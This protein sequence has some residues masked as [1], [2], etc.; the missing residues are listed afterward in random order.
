[1]KVET[2][3]YYCSKIFYMK[4][5]LVKI[6]T[7]HGR[8]CSA[9]CRSKFAAQIANKD[10]I[11]KVIKNC[12]FCG[13]E[14]HLQPYRII[15]VENNFCSKS[16][17]MKYGLKIKWKD[18]KKTVNV[19]CAY[20]GEI[21]TISE[22]DK[23]QKEKRGQE[24]FFCDRVCFG[25]WKSAN[26][27]G[28]NNPSWKGGWTPHG[29]GWGIIRDVV[30]KEQDYKCKDCKITE[31]KLGKQLDIHHIIPARLFKRKADASFRTN[32]VGLCHKCHMKREKDIQ[33]NRLV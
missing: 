22:W 14:I 28:E 11:K 31:D 10:R 20:C 21:K 27:N 29:T 7:K 3:C 2:T 33:K 26:W 15:N 5:Y 16:C 30:R 24:Q 18:G 23:Q 4:S 25:K 19:H 9:T 12:A 8:F 17:G 1:M 13:K 6:P 32:L